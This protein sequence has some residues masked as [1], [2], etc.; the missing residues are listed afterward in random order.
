[1]IVR[2]IAANVHN[3]QLKRAEIVSKMESSG[4]D[5]IDPLSDAEILQHLEDSYRD[6]PERLSE[7]REKAINDFIAVRKTEHETRLKDEIDA[8]TKAAIAK[9]KT[10][11]PPLPREQVDKYAA[12]TP[13]KQTAAVQEDLP[14]LEKEI[15][16][17]EPD[18]EKRAALEAELKETLAEIDKASA[19]KI[20]DVLLPCVTSKSR[21]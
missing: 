3:L 18:P 8:E 10:D 16:D 5:T 17:S 21:G 11:A 13:E 1:M 14:T 7:A 20:V 15:L 9:V 4:P 19:A 12:K 6:Y 2:Q